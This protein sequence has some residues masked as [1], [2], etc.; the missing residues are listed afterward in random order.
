MR[1]IIPVTCSHKEREGAREGA[2]EEGASERG[3]RVSN[4]SAERPQSGADAHQKNFIGRFRSGSFHGQLPRFRPALHRKEAIKDR[5]EERKKEQASATDCATCESVY[6]HD[7][8]HA[9]K[10][11]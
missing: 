6:V 8:S 2:R 9:C 11:A 10:R 5:V 1:Q 3:S 4:V 7:H